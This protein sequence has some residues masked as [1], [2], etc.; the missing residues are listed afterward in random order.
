VRRR[1]SDGETGRKEQ[2]V[3]VGEILLQKGKITAEQLQAALAARKS[4]TDRV[5]RI[6]IERGHVS[7]RE[8]LEIL[9]EQLSIPVVDLN[10]TGVD[11][12]LLRQMPS[13]LVHRRGLVPIGKENGALWVAV[14]DPFDIYAIDELRMMTGLRVEMVLASQSDINKIIK[15]YYGVGGETV[16]ELVV[17]D[18]PEL[19]SEIAAAET[20]DLEMAQEASVVKLVNEIVLE[21][22]NERASDIHIEPM[23]NDLKIRYRIDGVLHNTSIPQQIRRFQLAIISRIKIMSNLNIAE[24]RLPQDGAFKLRVHGREI[25]FRVSV[26]PAAFGEGVVIR[27]LD[28]QSVLFSLTQLGMDEKTYA[29]FESLI[30]RPHG[31]ILVTGPTGSGKTTTLY[32]ALN[33]IVS[34]E[35]KI[36]TIEDPIE[37]HLEGVNQVQVAPKIGLSFAHGL[38]SFLRHDPDVIL[39]G[40]IRDRE[41]AEVAINASLTGHLVF[42]TL[43]TNDAAGATTRLM[44]MGVEPFLVASSVE[45]VMAQRLVRTTCKS[46]KEP[47]KPDPQTLPTD[48]KYNGE[49]LYRGAGCRECRQSGF[50]GR[51]GMFELMMMTEEVRE[52]IM[53]QASTGRI[54]TLAR[55]Q[56]LVLLREDGWDKVRAGI[57]T[58]EEVARVT[59]I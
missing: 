54:I 42:S 18:E 3:S 16:E 56:G 50:S 57:T 26:I 2:A 40:E 12:E 25:D 37:Y 13:K 47:Y 30:T 8:V 9:G 31:I 38:R 43:H 41:T 23:E 15:Q 44:D 46:C 59:K 52:L 58:P 4:P 7:E 19:I 11:V 55:K 34:D 21:A 29:M 49:T 10:E 22:I 53:Q 48:L 51:I 5:E 14:S 35:I 28:K 20:A 32:A 24:K 36:L 6:L 33:T 1:P 17:E 27:I 39:V 45:G